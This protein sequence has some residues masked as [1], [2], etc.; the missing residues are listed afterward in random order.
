MAGAEG[1]APSA[2]E[3]RTLVFSSFCE[4]KMA[5]AEGFEPPNGGTRTHC[6]TTWRHPIGIYYYTT[7]LNT[8]VKIDKNYNL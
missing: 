7:Y 5:G 8:V 2:S 4:T 3:V 6:L 1:F